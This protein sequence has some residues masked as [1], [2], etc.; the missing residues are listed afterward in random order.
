M[1]NQPETPEQELLHQR[2]KLVLPATPEAYYLANTA[3][4]TDSP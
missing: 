3:R 2:E 4:A 1:V